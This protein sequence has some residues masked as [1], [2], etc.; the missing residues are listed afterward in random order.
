MGRISDRTLK[1]IGSIAAVIS[2]LLFVA[3]LMSPVRADTLPKGK[4]QI[5]DPVQETVKA[6]SALNC[7]LGIHGSLLNGD[8]DFGSPVN[9][10]SNGNSLGGSA[11]CGGRLGIFYVG[12]GL[13]YAR[14]YGNLKTIGVNSDMSVF[15]KA[16]L[17]PNDTTMIYLLL[18][19]AR[20]DTSLG[21]FDGWGY[22]GGITTKL[23]TSAPLWL[24]FQA[25]RTGFE[26]LMGSTIDANVTEL[27]VG[28]T[29]KLGGQ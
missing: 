18:A 16:G 19:K 6:A 29:Y 3:M 23:H 10:G 12:A 2:T 27:R 28:L 17:M 5:A 25:R 14:V 15:G 13:D 1:V 7:G 24:D 9:I 11:E 22:G 4:S 20:M 8:L 26:D 21:K